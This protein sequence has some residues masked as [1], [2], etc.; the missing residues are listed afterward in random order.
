[1]SEASARTSAVRC[2]FPTPGSPTTSMACRSPDRASSSA[3]R[4]AASSRLR[5][6]SRPRASSSSWRLPRAGPTTSAC[7]GA[8]FPLTSKGGI[9][10]RSNASRTPLSTDGVASTLPRSA[11]D[12]TRAARLT[13]SPRSDQTRRAGG[14]MSAVNTGPRFTPTRIARGDSTST[15][16]RRACSMRSSSSGEATGAPALRISFAP[17]ASTSDDT[18]AMP[19]SRHADATA[20]TT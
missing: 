16:S 10:V 2:D 14:P 8:F 7:T 13:S 9:G 18:S 20:P 11:L 4:S 1:M 6:I 3:E 15:M 19:H 17:S 12:I 5:P